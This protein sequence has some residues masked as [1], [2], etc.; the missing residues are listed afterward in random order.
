[1]REG[2]FSLGQSFYILS[3]SFLYS[4]DLFASGRVAFFFFAALYFFLFPIFFFFLERLQGIRHDQNVA[5]TWLSDYF[6]VA[7]KEQF[8]FFI[9]C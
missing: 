7:G 5:S 8:C 1:M 6:L 9:Y 2:I 3:S 4:L